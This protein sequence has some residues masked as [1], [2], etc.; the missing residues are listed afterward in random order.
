MPDLRAG[1]F[2]I[3]H[4]L[5]NDVCK[6]NAPI[7]MVATCTTIVG[8]GQNGCMHSK[9]VYRVQSSYGAYHNNCGIVSGVLYLCQL[10]DFLLREGMLL[11]RF[12]PRKI[13]WVA[14]KRQVCVTCTSLEYTPPRE[15]P[16]I[17]PLLMFDSF[18]L[19]RPPSLSSLRDSSRSRGHQKP[20]PP[21]ATY[22]YLFVENSLETVTIPHG[23]N[24]FPGDGCPAAS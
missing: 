7:S 17:S 10:A 18:S 12:M 4:L 21:L 8:D 9:A 19:G 1:I 16:L 24:A 2:F 13:T 5:H 6:R 23:Q 14:S 22:K 20:T 15:R 11:V 3:C